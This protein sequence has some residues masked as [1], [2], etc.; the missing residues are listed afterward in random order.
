MLSVNPA[1]RTPKKH[2]SAQFAPHEFS[3][4]RRLQRPHRPDVRGADEIR[5]ENAAPQWFKRRGR[6]RT[7]TLRDLGSRPPR[8]SRIMGWSLRGSR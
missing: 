2:R 4:T 8:P 5:V 3:Q 6:A 1:D 7:A